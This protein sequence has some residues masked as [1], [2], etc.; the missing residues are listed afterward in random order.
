[1]GA[2]PSCYIQ[3]PPPPPGLKTC[4]AKTHWLLSISI[5]KFLTFVIFKLPH[6]TR[7]K[8]NLQNFWNQRSLG[9]LKSAP[10]LRLER[11]PR[12]SKKTNLPHPYKI[13]AP[14]ERCENV[15]KNSI[16]GLNPSLVNLGQFYPPIGRR[17]SSQLDVKVHI[18]PLT[19]F[20]PDTPYGVKTLHAKY[21]QNRN[22]GFPII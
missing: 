3:V 19:K 10:A 17:K 1:M 21:F 15:A 4:T 18:T 7:G 2:S 20:R 16:K 12:F 8:Q 9:K 6:S 5:S 11:G 13:F 14:I 22:C